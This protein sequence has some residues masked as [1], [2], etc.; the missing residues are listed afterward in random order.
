MKTGNANQ[1]FLSDYRVP[2]L[3]GALVWVSLILHP[4]DMW[5]GTIVSFA[6]SSKNYS[7]IERLTSD[8][9]LQ[10]IY[11]LFRSEFFLAD[12]F[13]TKFIVID[14]I[15]VGIAVLIICVY[16]KKFIEERCQLEAKWSSMAM[17]IFL[18]FPIWHIL[19]SSTQT[20]YLIFTAMGLVGIHLVFGRGFKLNLVGFITLV[21]S[22]EM[23]S[24]MMF[25]PVLAVIYQLTEFDSK[26]FLCR[27]FRPFLVSTLAV[28]Y[29]IVSHAIS[30]PSGQYLGYNKI[31]N[32]FSLNGWKVIEAGVSSYSSFAILP[33]ISISALICILVFFWRPTGTEPSEF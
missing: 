4:R 24:L 6:A 23:N 25:V 15:I 3:L 14:R 29:W 16:I 10:T 26:A 5:D 20:F 28:I 19:T 32:P 27:I 21:I 11:F 17:S 18:T 8:A 1:R 31:V 2:T 7:G 30:S 33:I 22:F 13:H 9:D 12:F